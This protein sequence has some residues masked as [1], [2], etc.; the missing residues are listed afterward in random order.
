VVKKWSDKRMKIYIICP[1]CDGDKLECISLRDEILCCL[2]CGHEFQVV[3][4]VSPIVKWRN[5]EQKNV[6]KMINKKEKT[7]TSEIDQSE[8][9]SKND[10]NTEINGGTW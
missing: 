7:V 8:I 5:S 10:Q 1:R 4:I 9:D 6:I 3:G 2:Q